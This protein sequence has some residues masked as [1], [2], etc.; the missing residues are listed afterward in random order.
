MFIEARKQLIDWVQKQLIGPPEPAA[1]RSRLRG[2][3]P[4]ERFP[5]GAIG[6]AQISDF[7]GLE[8]EV[9]ILVDMP[10]PGH[11]E[12]VRPL[13]YVGM[14]RARAVEHDLSLTPSRANLPN[15]VAPLWPVS[16]GRKCRAADY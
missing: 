1:G 7:K 2:V 9:V 3:L 10:G 12:S 13:H 6:F 5:C 11:S 4:T 14:S 8:S 16:G 15:R